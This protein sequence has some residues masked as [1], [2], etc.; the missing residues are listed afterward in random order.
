MN[1]KDCC[2]V[3]GANEARQAMKFSLGFKEELEADLRGEKARS[4]TVVLNKS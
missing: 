4:Q 2:V 3:R 1:L